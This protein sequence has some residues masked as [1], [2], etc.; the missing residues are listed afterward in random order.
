[1]VNVFGWLTSVDACFEYRVRLPFTTLNRRP[2]WRC[3]WGAPG[4]DIGNYDVVVGQRLAGVQPDWLA[5]CRDPNTLCVYDMDDDL[6]H[7][8]PENSVPYQLYAPVADETRRNV[9]AADVVTVCTPQV[10]EVMAAINPRVVLLPICTD[11][12]WIDLPL[13]TTPGRLTVGWGGSPF[14]GQDWDVL[15]RHLAEYARLVP[16]AGC[17]M[18]GADYTCGAFGG[19]LRVTGLQPLADY[20]AAV[21]LDIGLAPLNPALHGSRTRSWTKPLEYAARGVPVVAQACGQYPQ[22]VRDGVNGFLIDDERDWVPRLLALSDDGVRAGMSTAA[23]DT[24]RQWTIDAHIG[25]WEQVYSGA[26][27]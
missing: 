14:H 6:L 8:D 4:P 9:A 13:R 5:L 12:A 17:H 7:I 18:F 22:W 1:M 2:G 24:A 20:L 10:A 21:D 16:D 19:R 3:V 26:V 23:R 25:L 11:P 15:P 27:G